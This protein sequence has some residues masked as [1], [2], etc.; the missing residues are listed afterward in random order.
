MNLS[1]LSRNRMWLPV[2]VGLGFC[3]VS[4]P[5]L[6]AP[7]WIAA[8]LGGAQFALGLGALRSLHNAAGLFD[9]IIAVCSGVRL[10]DFDQRL[11]EPRATG[12]MRLV[13]D[14]INGLID[15]N[16]AFVREAALAMR[17]VSQGRY[18]RKIRTE[19]MKGA[20]LKS[21][22]GI[23][24]AI[25]Q[26][27]TQQEMIGRSIAEAHRL[28]EAATNGDLTQRID[29]ARFVGV[30]A[31]FTHSMNGLLDAVAEPISATGNVLNALAESDLSS[32]MSGRYRGEFARLQD[33]TNAVAEAMAKVISQIR[34]TARTLKSATGEILAGTNDLSE[35]TTR[36][37]AAIEQTSAAMEQLAI[38][39]IDNVQRADK[40]K[41]KT[42]DVSR[43]AEAGGR[44]M[45]EA[46]AA[47]ERITSSSAQIASIIGL[48]D[49]IAFQT[50]LL[51]LNASVEAARA[52]EAGKGFAVVAVEVRRL[53]LS[54]ADA[55]RDIKA[56]IER[57]AA[58]VTGG[59]RLVADAAGKLTAMLAA[60]RENADLVEG[61]ASASREQAAA[62]EEVATAVR[63]MDEMTQH[64]AALVEE[65]NAAIEQTEAQASELDRIID[66]FRIAEGAEPTHALLPRR[67]VAS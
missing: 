57:S 25:D 48:I 2:F 59:S 46:T 52:G 51:A 40:A 9:R 1:S 14:R 67:L 18:Y 50:N 7:P 35:R 39:V 30:H 17:A 5:L 27:A 56:L 65:T 47:M 19:G 42:Q 60:V 44:V 16:D 62:I 4:A 3:A 53:A 8:L 64:N 32:R 41:G 12:Q 20:F 61:I 11:N 24:Q 34:G 55:S 63:Q 6:G 45:A 36:Q 58:E 26:M 21:V 28:A 29:T 38:T 22:T 37:A 43:T 23:N 13:V 66:V 10:G 49:D 33:D 31:E 15:I 54:A